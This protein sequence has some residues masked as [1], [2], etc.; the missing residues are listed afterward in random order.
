MTKQ[1]RLVLIISILASFVAFLDSSVVSVGLPAISGE[2]GGGLVT[3]QWVV[4]AYLIT[5]GALMLI[6]GSFSD[7]FGRKKVMAV[8]VVTF[9]LTSVL[10]A[11]APNAAF[12]IVSRGLQGIAGALL[13][14]SSLALIIS[15]FS[16][17]AQGK[18]IGSWTGWTG[19]AFVIGPLLGGFL[20]DIGSW[21]YIFA[22]N[23][24]PAAATLWLMRYLH[25]EK[26]VA[27][28]TKIDVTGAILGA[29]GL[30]GPVYALIEQAHYGWD[31]PA[32]YLPFIIGIIAAVMFIRHERRT[33]A[34]MLP[35][36]LFRVGN[37]AA[38]NIAT[39]AVYSG[40][41]VASF[42]ITIFI[43]Q[44]GHYSATMAGLSLIPVT[45]IMFALS[46]R[47]GALSGKYGPRLFMTLGPIVAAAGFLFMLQVDANVNYWAHILPGVLIFG[48]GLSMT[49]APLTSAVLG[50]I[51]ERHAGIGS[52]INNAIARIAGL[53]AIAAL[54]VI[55][56]SNLDVDGFHRGLIATAALLIVGG[57]ISAIGISNA[58]VKQAKVPVDSLS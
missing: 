1:Q 47:F 14:P 49:V 2:L 34:P 56:G 24:I 17:A 31:S 35:I 6:A 39:I 45:F 33:P 46:P 28:Q 7:L 8:G 13:V 38:G 48:L 53:L 50:S 43:Q 26:R 58:V 36:S 32:I 4:D 52:A 29:I 18:A 57:V 3:Q 21:R 55:I 51:D 25:A 22:I 42:L 40:L 54:G 16:G 30:G 9:A 20:V 37:F 12:L 27:K 23:L 44:V 41:S 5:L 15:A 11:I 19:I 10:C